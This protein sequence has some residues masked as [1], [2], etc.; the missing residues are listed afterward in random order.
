MRIW[1]LVLLIKEVIQY[2]WTT[3]LLIWGEIW[4]IWTQIED[5]LI[6]NLS[7][8]SQVLA[9]KVIKKIIIEKNNMCLSKLTFSKCIIH[10]KLISN[11]KDWIQCFVQRTRQNYDMCPLLTTYHDLDGPKHW[12]KPSPILCTMSF[13]YCFQIKVNIWTNSFMH[14]LHRQFYFYSISLLYIILTLCSSLNYPL[15][16]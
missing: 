8:I 4:F 13:E 2:H 14:L 11:D 3:K 16:L 6:S 7:H 15:L 5:K 9:Q 10:S 1:I 12:T